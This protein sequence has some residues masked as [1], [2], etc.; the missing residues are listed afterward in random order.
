[1][2]YSAGQKAGGKGKLDPGLEEKV[3]LLNLVGKKGF[4]NG[5]FIG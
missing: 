3:E 4:N 1:M 5:V 2:V